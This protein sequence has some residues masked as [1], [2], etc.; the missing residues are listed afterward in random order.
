[1]TE[2][3]GASFVKQAITMIVVDKEEAKAKPVQPPSG[4]ID[5]NAIEN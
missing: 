3:V 4:V 5:I 2:L 1:M